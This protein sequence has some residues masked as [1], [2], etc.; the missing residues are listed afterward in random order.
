[1]SEVITDSR[2]RRCLSVTQ[3]IDDVSFVERHGAKTGWMMERYNAD[4]S[5]RFYGTV[6]RNT[7]DSGNSAGRIQE[8]PGRIHLKWSEREKECDSLPDI[9][10]VA[11]AVAR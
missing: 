3:D 6:N 5:V 9:H 7:I 11:H 10:G 1:M 8:L 2:N 4:F